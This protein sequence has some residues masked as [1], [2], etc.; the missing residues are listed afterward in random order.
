[1]DPILFVTSI[2]AKLGYFGVA[3]AVFIENIFPPIPSEVVLPFAGFAAA[4]GKLT[5]T[6]VVIAATVG[7]LLGAILLYMFGRLV[8]DA[9]LRKLAAKYGKFIGVSYDDITKSKQWFDKHGHKAVFLG[10]MIPGIRTVVSIP[11]GISK[12]SF[13]PF[14]LWSGVGTAIWSIAL[15]TA[16]YFLGSQYEVVADY[17]A[18]VS[19]VILVVV[20]LGLGWFIIK[21]VLNQRSKEESNQ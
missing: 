3:A 11:A 1:M 21:R 18:P 12:M 14:M 16:G 19:K 9:R 20:V 8:S 7:S 15:I 17:I 5:F 13:V 10:R 4:Q 2:I 6:G